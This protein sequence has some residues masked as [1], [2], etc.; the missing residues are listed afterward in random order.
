MIIG[1]TTT[2][3]ATLDLD[4]THLPEAKKIAQILLSQFK[5]EGFLILRSSQKSYHVIFNK[6]LTW[7]VALQVI[8]SAEPCRKRY[9]NRLSWAEMQAKKGAAT[10]RIGPKC[11]KKSPYSVFKVG[12]QD[13]E[14]KDYLKLKK[15]LG[16]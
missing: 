14:I 11:R 2:K 12:K 9:H 1:Y 16:I 3:A 13:K 5:L 7:R 10:L 8:F 15:K 6:P 4:N